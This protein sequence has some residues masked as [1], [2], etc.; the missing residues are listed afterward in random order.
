MSAMPI[1]KFTPEEYLRRERLAPFRSELFGGRIVAMAGASPVHNRIVVN[2]ATL[3]NA[4]FRGGPCRV[5]V[6]DQRIS[7][8]HR[9]GYYY[10]DVVITCGKP[11]FSDDQRDTL[12]NP[13]VIIEV[14]SRSTEAYDRGEKFRDYQKIASLQEYVLITQSPR[15]FEVF[16]RQPDEKWLYASWEFSPP[17]I[18]LPSIGCTLDADDVYSDIDFESEGNPEP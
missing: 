6:N 13:V 2:L 10:P 8:G 3:L 1:P 4:K 7:I 16:Q 12:T 18:L 11:V 17:P 9:Q 15:R 5:Y 14:L